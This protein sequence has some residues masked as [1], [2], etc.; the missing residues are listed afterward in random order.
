MVAIWAV[1]VLCGCA[2]QA[3]NG[4]PI[5]I[6]ETPAPTAAASS[7][8]PDAVAGGEVVIAAMT[9]LDRP[10]QFGG[11]SAEAGFD[12]SGFT[13]YVFGQA[14]GVELPRSAE[15][16]AQAPMLRSVSSRRA[17]QPGDLVFFNTLQRTFSHVGIYVGDGRFIHA[18][19]T[20]A[21]VRIES[22][23]ATY[24]SRRYTGARRVAASDVTP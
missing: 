12:C 14:L 6:G 10:Y 1:V 3:P 23:H 4:S 8:G 16:Q 18:P 13:R 20:G 2:T 5:G 19:R 15:E 24:W 21:Q 7:N 11:Q 22:I 17:L 9:F